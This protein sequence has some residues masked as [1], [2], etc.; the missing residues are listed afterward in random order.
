[1]S[2]NPRQMWRP[3]LPEVAVQCASCPFREGNDDEFRAVLK[4]MLGASVLTEEGLQDVRDEIKESLQYSGDFICH[5]TALKVGGELRPL[6][7]RRQCPGATAW[8]RSSTAGR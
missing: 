6:Q 4:K 8:F 2:T 7:D 1:M 5:H 3:K